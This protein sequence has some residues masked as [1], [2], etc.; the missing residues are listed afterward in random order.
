LF[1][2]T[3]AESL[4]LQWA[5]S[6]NLQRLRLFCGIIWVVRISMGRQ[7]ATEG[8]SREAAAGQIP[9]RANGEDGVVLTQAGHPRPP[10]LISKAIA[11]IR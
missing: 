9:A 10:P 7:P 1:N 5:T 3:L 11:Y 4:A 8:A 2:Q 6:R